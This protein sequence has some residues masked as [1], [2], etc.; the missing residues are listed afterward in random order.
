MEL[1]NIIT[2][3]H[4]INYLFVQNWSVP[5]GFFSVSPEDP[6]SGV[7]VTGKLPRLCDPPVM[8]VLIKAG[9]SPTKWNI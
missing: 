6:G 7:G 8:P 9:P 5:G 3:F 1:I 4:K 2:V